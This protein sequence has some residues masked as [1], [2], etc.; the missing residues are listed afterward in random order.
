M[1]CVG[2]FNKYCV[3]VVGKV[4]RVARDAMPHCAVVDDIENLRHV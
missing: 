1:N 4:E 3:H 2:R